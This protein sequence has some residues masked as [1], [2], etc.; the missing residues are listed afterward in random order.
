MVG[1]DKGEK[2]ETL[3]IYGQASEHCPAWVAGNRE[4]LLRLRDAIDKAILSD[5]LGKSEVVFCADGEGYT[6]TVMKLGAADLGGMAMPYTAD[7]AEMAGG[8]WPWEVAR[9]LVPNAPHKPRSV[10]ESA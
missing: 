9:K 2:M 5:G 8:V 3:H 1:H 10:A 6:V 4:G 7:E